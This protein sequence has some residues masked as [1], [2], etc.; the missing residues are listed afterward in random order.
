MIIDFDTSIKDI[1]TL[2]QKNN[3]SINDN[4]LNAMLKMIDHGINT[5]KH[6]ILE[7]DNY[8]SFYFAWNDS[9]VLMFNNSG[10]YKLSYVMGVNRGD[11]TSNEP[12]FIIDLIEKLLCS[13]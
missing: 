5:T 4:S 1:I 12:Q 9:M 2:A 6:P 13:N 7:L 10:N 11:I 8:G 3:I